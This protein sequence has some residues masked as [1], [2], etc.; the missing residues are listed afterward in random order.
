ML[1]RVDGNES[2]WLG[3]PRPAVS[4]SGNVDLSEPTDPDDA[5][6]DDVAIKWAESLLDV[7]RFELARADDKANTL[8]RFYGVVAALSIGLLAGSTAS[9]TNLAISAQL[10]FWAGCAAFLASGIYLGMTLYPRD[11]R[12]APANRLLYFGHVIEYQSVDELA[13]GLQHVKADSGRRVVEQ[14]LS[15]SRLVHAKYA[16]TRKALIALGVG[17]FLCIFSVLLNVIIAHI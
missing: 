5:G 8:F 6:L 2:R 16:L 10:F 14:L 1:P 13:A 7:A 9:P 15:V 12:G 11:I 17:T 4:P 3:G